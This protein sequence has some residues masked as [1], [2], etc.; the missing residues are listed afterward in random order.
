MQAVNP[1]AF[2]VDDLAS[3]ARQSGYEGPIEAL[4]AARAA[5]EF[6]E[7]SAC[8]DDLICVTGSFSVVGEMRSVLEL[9]PAR[10]M[11]LDEVTVQN[12]QTL[13]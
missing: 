5:L 6:A 13:S 4:P 2:D 12:L 7:S 9:P 8:P 11:Y 1:R 10:A 3:L